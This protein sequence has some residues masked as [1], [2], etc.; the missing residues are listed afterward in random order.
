MFS[1][2]MRT[3]IFQAIVIYACS[4]ILGHHLRGHTF[5]KMMENEGFMTLWNTMER[6]GLHVTS[7]ATH[8][9][10]GQ[11]TLDAG[12][13]ANET[14]SLNHTFATNGTVDAAMKAEE[15][16]YRR[17]PREMVVHLVIFALQYWWYIG[18]ERMLPARP[19]SKEVSNQQ[20]ARVELSEDREEEVV[21]KW[22]AKYNEPH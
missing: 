1:P 17:L 9:T 15:S 13:T 14:L 8:P 19:R 7:N 16:F 5:D 6:L 18:L 20:A 12:H 4:A 3:A 10:S 21:Q 2:T 22:M 11:L